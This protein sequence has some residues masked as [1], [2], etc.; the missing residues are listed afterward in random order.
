MA[1]GAVAMTGG[2]VLVTGA[3]GYTG[4]R[5]VQRLLRAGV[6]VRALARAASDVSVLP[7]GVD[8]VTGDLEAAASLTAACTGVH[9]VYHLAGAWHTG[10]LLRGLPASVERVVIVSSLRALSRV[11]SDSVQQ[12][13]QGEA[14]AEGSHIPNTILRSSMIFGDGDDR[15]ISRLAVRVRAGTWIPAIGRHCLHQPVYVHDL[16]DAITSCAAA[17]PPTG[18][19]YAIAGATAL[20]WGELVDAV[21]RAVGRRPRWLPVPERLA[22]SA[23]ALFE[24]GGLRLPIRAEQLQRLQEDKTYDISPARRDLSYDPQSFADSLARI[25]DG[26]APTS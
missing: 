11:P 1:V 13:L 19:T 26:G 4:Q 9:Q 15:N 24:R 23:L 16:I 22:V 7:D 3:T 18:R 10:N 14:A 21:G 2:Y 5:L 8:I 20:T 25:H 6:P 17:A 12:V